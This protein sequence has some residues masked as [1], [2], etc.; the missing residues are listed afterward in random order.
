[1]VIAYLVSS[2]L[3]PLMRHLWLYAGSGNANFFYALTIVYTSAHVAAAVDL[4]HAYARRQ[5][6][7][8]EGLAVPDPMDDIILR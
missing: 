2:G 8:T 3:L 7:L 1:M 5:H 6:D 4:L